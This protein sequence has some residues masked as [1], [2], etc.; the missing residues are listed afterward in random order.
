[1]HLAKPQGEPLDRIVPFHRKI[2]RIGLANWEGGKQNDRF[3]MPFKLL[4]YFV[5]SV[6]KL[7]TFGFKYFQTHFFSFLLPHRNFFLIAAIWLDQTAVCFTQMTTGLCNPPLPLR[8]LIP[9]PVG[10]SLE[11]SRREESGTISRL[12]DGRARSL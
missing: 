12:G 4:N 8:G 10:F 9:H 2:T 1:M 11:V 6:K 7:L 5:K 3:F